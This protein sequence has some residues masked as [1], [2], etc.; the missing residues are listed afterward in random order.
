LPPPEQEPVAA[1]AATS[2][3]GSQPLQLAAVP[4]TQTVI[5]ASYA[6][7]ITNGQSGGTSAMN[8]VSITPAISPWRSPQ[9]SQSGLPSSFAVQ[10]SSPNVPGVVPQS[11]TMDVQLRAVPSPPPEPVPP[12]TPRIR[13][14]S[15]AAPQSV[16]GANL[17][18]HPTRV[19]AM[20]TPVPSG[21][22]LQ[23]VQISPLPP[24]PYDPAANLAVAPQAVGSYDG[25]RPRSSMR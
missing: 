3:A 4:A 22:V 25:F 9:I 10:S 13:L 17:N 11:T 20:A 23:T 21:S 18:M 5:P 1:I 12:S 8:E 19:E 7:P 2:G 15:Y 14:P 16:G 24:P 6:A